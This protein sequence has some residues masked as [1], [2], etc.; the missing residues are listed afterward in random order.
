ME[1][2]IYD[3]LRFMKF[4]EGSDTKGFRKYQDLVAKISF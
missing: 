1:Y 2:R 3:T 4:L